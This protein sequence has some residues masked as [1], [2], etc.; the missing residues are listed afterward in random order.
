MTGY[1]FAAETRCTPAS[2]RAEIE[3]LLAKAGCARV[4]IALD[5]AHSAIAFELDNRRY[6]FEIAVPTRRDVETLPTGQPRRTAHLAAAKE[7]LLKIRWRTLLLAIRAQLAMVETGLALTH[8]DVLLPYL[9][10][11]SGRTLAEETREP[12][13]L[14]Y[15]GHPIPLLGAA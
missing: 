13:K 5:P 2:T 4:R 3:A 12:I 9:I 7:Q 10:L 15:D 1:H 11:P 14:A 8:Q 6:R